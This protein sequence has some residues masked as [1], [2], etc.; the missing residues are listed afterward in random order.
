MG[1]NS[2]FGTIEHVE[3]YA[4]AYEQRIQQRYQSE[5]DQLT[6]L[7]FNHLFYFGEAFSV[8]RLLLVFPLLVLL[9]MRSKGTPI[10]LYQGTK[11]LAG[12][13]V[14]GARDKTAY[15]H[16]NSF[17]VTFHTAFRDGSVLLS[18]TYADPL[19]YIPTTTSYG[20][21]ASIAD[22]WAA[23]QGRIQDM[24]SSGKR[25][26]LQTSFAFYSEMVRKEKPTG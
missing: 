9:A 1:A 15:A 16:P 17:G 14:L 22:T 20:R 26:D 3:I 23:H 6:D 25:V 18:K 8:F 11:V 7:G 13:P 10:T 21:V 12:N 19:T 5:V 4:P 2:T 24:E